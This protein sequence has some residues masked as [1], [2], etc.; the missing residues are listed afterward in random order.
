MK[1]MWNGRKAV[2]GISMMVSFLLKI[3]FK[4]AL[5]FFMGVSESQKNP[6]FGI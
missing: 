4:E 6:D 2:C 1:W 3:F 5:N